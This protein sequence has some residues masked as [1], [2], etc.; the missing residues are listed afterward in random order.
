MNPDD[1]SRSVYAVA[2]KDGRF[3]MVYNPKRKGWDEGIQEMALKCN[4]IQGG[5]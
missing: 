5:A 2:F 3:L 4:R 1:T